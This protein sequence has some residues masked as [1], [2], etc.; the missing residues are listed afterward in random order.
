MCHVS[1]VIFVAKYLSKDEIVGK[2]VIEVGSYDEME[3]SDL[4]YTIGTQQSM[5]ELT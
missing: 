4:S 3:P 1:C 2:R 5:S